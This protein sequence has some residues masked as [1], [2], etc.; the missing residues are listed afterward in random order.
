[1]NT[2]SATPEVVVYS[3]GFC[4]WC[5]RAKAL[6]KSRN[7][8]FRDARVDEDPAAREEMMARSTERS[9]PQIFIGERHVGGFEAL[10]ALDRSG[11]LGKLWKTP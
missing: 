4:G 8:P 10:Y 7:I 11:E 3:T 1:M 5:E 6:L 2:A 9:V